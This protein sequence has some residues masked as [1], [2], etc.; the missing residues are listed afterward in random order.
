[1][2]CSHKRESSKRRCILSDKEAYEPPLTICMPRDAFPFIHVLTSVYVYAD[3]CADNW[4]MPIIG[5]LRYH[6]PVGHRALR[7]NKCS[8][9]YTLACV[10][11]LIFC[12]LTC[13]HSVAITTLYT[14]LPVFL[15]M[16]PQLYGLLVLR[17]I[18]RLW[19]CLLML[20]LEW[21]YRKR[22]V[23]VNKSTLNNLCIIAH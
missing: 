20:E 11:I 6:V 17:V 13:S 2:N 4:A 23:D 14:C 22:F 16:V 7:H 18:S 3:N 21:I 15:R 10:P 1:M 19:N 12:M 9:N 8:L 5:S